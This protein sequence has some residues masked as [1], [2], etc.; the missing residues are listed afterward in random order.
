M[1]IYFAA[2]LVPPSMEMLVGMLAVW[3]LFR[4]SRDTSLA[5]L[6]VR[7]CLGHGGDSAA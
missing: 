4:L 5:A 7:L 1:A 3:A 2:E 6:V